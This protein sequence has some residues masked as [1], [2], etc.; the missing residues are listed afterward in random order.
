MLLQ[1]RFGD[2]LSRNHET[3]VVRSECAWWNTPSIGVESRFALRGYV[4]ACSSRPSELVASGRPVSFDVSRRR[5]SAS[6]WP[7]V[8]R[9]GTETLVAVFAPEPQVMAFMLSLSQRFMAG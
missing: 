2:C 4:G 3:S 8:G 6:R 1:Q 7:V 5:G 9:S